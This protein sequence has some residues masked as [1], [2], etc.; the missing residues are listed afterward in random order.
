MFFGSMILK[1]ITSSIAAFASK[2]FVRDFPVM[3]AHM[4]LLVPSGMSSCEYPLA[5]NIVARDAR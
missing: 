4:P 2:A 3:L 1:A 5:S